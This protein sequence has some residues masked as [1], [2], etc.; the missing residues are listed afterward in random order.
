MKIFIVEDDAW[1]GEIIE[2]HLALNP[3]YEIRRF[4]NGKDFLKNL[5]QNPSVVTLDYSLPDVSCEVLMDYI[6]KFN[7]DLPIIIVSGQNDIATAVQLLKDGAYDY[8]VKNEETKDRL[9]NVIVKIKENLRLKDEIT[10]L[11]EEIQKKYDFSKA[12]KGNSSTIKHIFNLM[13]KAASTQ[14]NVSIMGET[15]T[16]KELVAKAVHYN[17]PRKKKPFIAINMSAIPK[18]LIESEL[19]GHEKGAFTGANIRRIGKFEQANL[20]TIFLDEI[21]EMDFNLQAKLLRVLQEKELNRVGGNSTVKIDVRIIIATNKNLA[22]EVTKGNFRED[23]YYRLLGLPV[24]LPP[25]RRRGRD[26][27]LLAKYFTDE[28]CKENKIQKKSISLEAQEK[29]MKY[30][31]PGN[32]R[33]LKAIMELAAVMANSELILAENIYFNNINPAHNFLQEE[34]SLKEYERKIIRHYLEKYDNNVKLVAEK[35]E[36]GK[37]TLYRM[38]KNEEV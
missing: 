2:Y 18:E 6:K 11:Q 25:L 24:K 37:S 35:L 26:I 13:A 36:I 3:D 16:G 22:D 5:Y 1:Y 28:F 20:G 23:L 31:F 12:I 33:E 32:V 7:A 4:N 17:S 34:M 21:S 27:L 30:N 9:W 15:G 29:L 38:V 8:I 14:I 19:F 10:H